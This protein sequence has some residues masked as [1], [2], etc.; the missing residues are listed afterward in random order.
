MF[1]LHQVLDAI[2][3]FLRDYNC[4]IDQEVQLAIVMSVIIPAGQRKRHT[5]FLFF[6]SEPPNPPK[7][8]SLSPYKLS[9]S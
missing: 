6:A 1:V 5:P 7:P 9:S 2:L 8:S 4:D 3:V